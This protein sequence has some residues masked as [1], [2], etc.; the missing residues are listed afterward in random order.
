LSTSQLNVMRH[1]ASELIDIK[2][3]LYTLEQVK[4]IAN[5]L[6]DKIEDA[7][8]YSKL[9]NFPNYEKAENLLI[10]TISEVNK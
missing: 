5:K 8:I 1:D 2:K 6:F 10:R 3:G 7:L 9:P 4:D